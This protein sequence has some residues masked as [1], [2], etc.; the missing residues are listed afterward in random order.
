MTTSLAGTPLFMAPEVILREEYNKKADM[1]SIGVT[2]YEICT[3]EYPFKGKS[4][5]EIVDQAR[6][7]P[8]PL[9]NLYPK[10]VRQLVMDLLNLDP[11]QRPDCDQ[12]LNGPIFPPSFNA[13]QSL[14]EPQ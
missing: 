6:K 10:E 14:I 9:P 5:G 13:D 7:P 8:P 3:F 2:L 4:F 11:E 12:I 1:W